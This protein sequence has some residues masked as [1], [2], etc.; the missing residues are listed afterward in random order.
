MFEE[1]ILALWKQRQKY[2]EEERELE[3]EVKSLLKKYGDA[4]KIKE[5]LEKVAGES[6]DKAVSSYAIKTYTNKAKELFKS[7]KEDLIK[8]Y[9]EGV[10]KRLSVLQVL[11]LLANLKEISEDTERGSYFFK[12][13]LNTIIKVAKNERIPNPFGT[14]KN[15]FFLSGKQTP[16][17]FL[18]SNF[19]EELIGETL[20]ELLE[21]EIEKLVA[22]EKAKEIEGKVKKLKEIVS[23]F[24]TLPYEIKQIAKE[25]ISD[26]VLDIAEK[27][28]KDMKE[29]NYSLDE[30]KAFLTSSPRDNLVNYMQY[31]KSI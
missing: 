3:R 26:N 17:D 30:A 29:C 21:K 23:W 1:E 25:V 15:D 4:E 27:F 10:L 20:G 18:L 2:I 14:L 31:L 12:K 5:I 24:E 6:F 13:G 28:Y 11:Y 16:Y 22:E 9:R 19:L 7:F 8:L